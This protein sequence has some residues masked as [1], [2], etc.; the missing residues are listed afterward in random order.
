MIKLKIKFLLLVAVPF[1]ISSCKQWAQVYKIDSNIS[2][3]GLF[4]LYETDSVQVTYWLWAQ[5]GVLS[6]AIY[7]KLDVPLYIDWKKSTF[8]REQDRFNYWIDEEVVNSLTYYKGFAFTAPTFTPIAHSYENGQVVTY[9]L[10]GTV[11]ANAGSSVS[12]SV[13]S[14]PERVTFI[15]PKSI[16][17]PAKP[18]FFIYPAFGTKLRK[19]R[20]FE[21]VAR[22][23]D[24]KKT[25]RLYKAEYEETNNPFAFRNFL[26]VSTSENFENEFYIDNKFFVAEILEMERKHFSG[27][28]IEQMDAYERPFTN[29]KDFYIFISRFA[30]IEYRKKHHMD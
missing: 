1:L 5:R 14:K 25:T 22:N 3:N 2:K 20:D 4:W 28:Y 19:D 15:P 6:F 24:P 11:S 18:M 17:Y 21:T 23:D 27:K 8:F 7:N 29:P 10:P 12:T 30:S 13:K 9:G 26:T 16:Y